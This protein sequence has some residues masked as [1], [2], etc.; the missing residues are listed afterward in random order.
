[1]RVYDIQTIVIPYALYEFISPELTKENNINPLTYAIRNS[2]L[3][4]KLSCMKITKTF[5]L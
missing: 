3:L 1:M 2:L 4:N 5:C